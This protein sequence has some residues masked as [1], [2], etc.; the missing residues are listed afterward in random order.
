MIG[1]F[2]YFSF[3]RGTHTVHIKQSRTLNR[4]VDMWHKSEQQ[5]N[6]LSLAT[7]LFQSYLDV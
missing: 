4:D 6:L 5:E 3:L 2:P 7:W 1:L